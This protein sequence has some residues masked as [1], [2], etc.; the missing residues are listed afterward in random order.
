[1]RRRVRVAEYYRIMPDAENPKRTFELY[2]EERDTFF[3]ILYRDLFKMAMINAEGGD[4]EAQDFANTLRLAYEHYSDPGAQA[5]PGGGD[6]HQHAIVAQLQGQAQAAESKKPDVGTDVLKTPTASHWMKLLQILQQSRGN[7]AASAVVMPPEKLIA[8]MLPASD[9][10]AADKKEQTVFAPLTSSL[11]FAV[12]PHHH[13]S[14]DVSVQANTDILHQQMPAVP[15]HLLDKIQHSL[16]QYPRAA[17]AQRLR[18]PAYLRSP[19]TFT[20]CDKDSLDYHEARIGLARMFRRYAAPSSFLKSYQGNK[21]IFNPAC[22]EQDDLHV[23]QMF[24]Q[25]LGAFNEPN[26]PLFAECMPLSKTRDV[27][28]SW[29][30][31][32]D[33]LDYLLVPGHERLS[34]AAAAAASV[35][36]TGC[37]RAEYSLKVAAAIQQELDAMGFQPQKGL[38][39]SQAVYTWGVNDNYLSTNDYLNPAESSGLNLKAHQALRKYAPRGIVTNEYLSKL[40]GMAGEFELAETHPWL[41]KCQVN[42]EFLLLCFQN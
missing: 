3:T 14:N 9:S 31:T 20:E 36:G 21:L 8:T 33:V 23:G 40:Q 27:H 37:S 30:L 22:L 26:H 7:L 32:E 28:G 41:H 17:V 19:F 18:S 39:A 34:L 6:R 4:R 5:Q 16:V 42:L 11:H 13:N 2:N 24:Y 29:I 25:P 15:K 38:A 12:V 35:D 10:D 1:M